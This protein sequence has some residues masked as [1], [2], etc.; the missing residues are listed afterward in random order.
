MSKYSTLCER[1]KNCVLTASSNHRNITI[2][3]SEGRESTRWTPVGSLCGPINL[4]MVDVQEC[5]EFEER[6]E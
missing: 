2:K 1:C 5:S 4:Y 3:D 6:E